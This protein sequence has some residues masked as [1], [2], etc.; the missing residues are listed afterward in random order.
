MPRFTGFA[1]ILSALVLAA[2]AASAASPTLESVV[3]VQRHGVRPPT[4][5][6]SSLAKYASQAWPDWPVAPGEL[7][8]HGAEAV[9]LLGAWTRAHYAA[10]GVLPAKGCP[11]SGDVFVWADG[12]DHRTVD[13]GNAML[14]G[15]APGCGVTDQH[16]TAGREDAVFAA[17]ESG[18]CPLP[19]AVAQ[20]EIPLVQAR[21]KALPASY[22]PALAALR[23]V[24]AP[25]ISGA[26]CNADLCFEDGKNAVGQDEGK[27]KVKGPLGTA[28]SLAEDL[29]LED[30]EGF[31]GDR[32][33]WGRLNDAKLTQIMTL[34]ALASDITRRDP[35]VAGH[36]GAMLAQ[37]VLAA[38]GGGAPLPA[39]HGKRARITV[40]L[41]H[42]TNLDNLAGIFGLTWSLPGQPDDTAPDT[43][44]VFE[45]WRDAPGH[46]T[47]R[48]F[49]R[50]QT[51]A[52]L[53]GLTRLAGDE[54]PG[55]VAL[56]PG[57][58]RA[59]GC[60]I[61]DLQRRVRQVVPEACLIK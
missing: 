51:L 3:I 41:G 37:D 44:L 10:L 32:L 34:H 2:P 38:L 12:A 17:M 6:A 19:D 15:L 60:D 61:A 35:A 14:R 49:V 39:Q 5:P 53:R 47:V 29:L 9:R 11:G 21:L 36:N 45:R 22:A 28:A 54:K 13:S 31:S 42:D 25:G 40:F 20:A 43:A 56:T 7:T 52:Q 57:Y 30:A 48:V 24:L 23:Q 26:A 59:A 16:G 27:A 8:P 33:G 58:C 18:Q 4:K 55:E 46:E 1:G 50:Y